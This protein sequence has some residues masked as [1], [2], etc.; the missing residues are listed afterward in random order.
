MKKILIALILIAG[1]HGQANAQFFK[2]LGN[3]IEK[4]S[5]TVDDVTNAILGEDSNNSSNTP[6]NKKQKTKSYQLGDT[7]VSIIGENPGVSMTSLH[8]TRVYGSKDVILHMQ[9]YNSSDESWKIYSD[10]DYC[11]AVDDNGNQFTKGGLDMENDNTFSSDRTAM[12]ILDDTKL[13]MNLLF[14]Y[15]NLDDTRFK[16]VEMGY[17]YLDHDYHTLDGTFRMDNVPITLLPSLKSDGV[18][19]E[20]KVIIGSAIANL[21]QAIPYMY[22]NY[23]I[24]KFTNDGKSY[25]L[26]TFTLGGEVMFKGISADQTTISY[27]C[28][29]TPH[30][31]FKVGEK[32]YKIDDYLYQDDKFCTPNANGDLTFKGLLLKREKSPVTYRE[33]IKRVF[34]GLSTK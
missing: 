10:I 3:A 26:I 22:D 27:I 18:Y 25:M 7:K 11:V 20:G 8:A 2:K 19:G 13:N 33:E 14:N 28:V 6:N 31:Q 4:A 21:P 24:S 5:K 15:V 9:F 16:R 23:T 29:D 30:V 1:V 12:T 17:Y 32:F 34:A